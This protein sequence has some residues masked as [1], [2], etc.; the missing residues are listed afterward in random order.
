VQLKTGLQEPDY[1]YA[2][3]IYP[4]VNQAMDE[5]LYLPNRGSNLC[6]RRH[7]AH[8]E[9]RETEPA[10]GAAGFNYTGEKDR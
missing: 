9:A 10:A 3:A 1:R 6:T 7:C 4:M 5:G 8:W 2:E